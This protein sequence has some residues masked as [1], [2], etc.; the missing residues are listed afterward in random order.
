MGDYERRHSELG[1]ALLNEVPANPNDP[2]VAV[3][4][5][6]CRWHH[7]RWDGGGYPDGLAGDEIPI[8]AQVVAMADVYDALTG[9]RC[10]KDAVPHDKAIEMICAGECGE[11]NPLL[12]HC[13]KNIAGKLDWNVFSKNRRISITKMRH[14]VL[15]KK[16]W[17]TSLC[18]SITEPAD[19]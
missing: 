6:I 2:L 10:Y 3:A 7:E 14:I 16:C 12:I 9:I 17:R 13:L 15:Q 4:Y 8:S 18:C 11:F 19:C 1:E 5:G